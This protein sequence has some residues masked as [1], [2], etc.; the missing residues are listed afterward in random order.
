MHNAIN[1]KSVQQTDSIFGSSDFWLNWAVQAENYNI[2][3]YLDEHKL[4][5][6]SSLIALLQWTL[7]NI[8][9]HWWTLVNI[10]EHWWTLVSIGEHWWTLWTMATIGDSPSSNCPSPV[11]FV[12]S[13]NII[14]V[15]ILILIYILPPMSSLRWTFAS[16]CSSASLNSR[17]AHTHRIL[18]P[19]SISRWILSEWVKT[20]PIWLFDAATLNRTGIRCFSL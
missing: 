17:I 9:E 4:L 1:V 12:T 5:W 11:S 19:Y 13:R 7:V 18:S 6:I 15:L 16:I 2:A 10:G 14:T 8:G 3:M 20:S